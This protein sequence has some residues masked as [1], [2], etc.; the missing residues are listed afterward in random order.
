MSD[1]GNFTEEGVYRTVCGFLKL[2][3]CV[4]TEMATLW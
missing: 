3:L 1:V 2:S 4:N